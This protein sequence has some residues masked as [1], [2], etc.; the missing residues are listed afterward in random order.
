MVGKRFF[1]E[2]KIYFR[3]ENNLERIRGIPALDIILDDPISIKTYENLSKT[4][5]SVKNKPYHKT[6]QFRKRIKLKMGQR[7]KY[8]EEVII[9]K[10]PPSKKFIKDKRGFLREDKKY[11]FI[12]GIRHC[13][14]EKWA[15]IPI[16]IQGLT[17]LGRISV[18]GDD[19]NHNP[20]S[21][22][23]F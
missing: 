9:L 4:P 8:K 18:A 10:S 14:S 13:F 11:I 17:I 7:R 23:W 5:I 12:D 15:V 2:S 20:F 16:T 3:S 6:K 21:G 1:N 22:G 19:K